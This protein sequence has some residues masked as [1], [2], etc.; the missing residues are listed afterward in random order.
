MTNKKTKQEYILEAAKLYGLGNV[1]INAL[2]AHLDGSEP[3][4]FI[5]RKTEY[6][7]RLYETYKSSEYNDKIDTDENGIIQLN[8]YA[9][10]FSKRKLAD[11]KIGT[12]WILS[13][14]LETYL[15]TK[16]PDYHSKIK[17]K[18]LKLADTN[19]FLLPQIA[20]QMGLDA[21][22]Y[23]RAEYIEHSDTLTTFHL[24]KNFLRDDETLIQGN[25]IVRESSKKKRV[26]KVNFETL[27]ETVDKYV[28]KYY[29]KHKL[30]T[31]NLNSVREEIR[32]NL[33]KQTIFNKMVFNQNESNQKW[34]L[35]K[36]PD[37]SLRTAPLFS[38]DYCSGVEM[39]QKSPHRVIDG[40][41]EDIES[42]MV[43]F[44]QEE[45]FREWIASSVL[46]LDLDKA[47]QDME[48]KTGISLS[49]EEKE[50]YQFFMNKMHDKIVSVHNL[51]YDK[52]LVEES[53]KI[54]LGDKIKRKLS[55]KAKKETEKDSGKD[56][57]ELEK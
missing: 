52:E 39:V 30:P 49:N 48:R 47:M 54:K 35:I 25:S 53:K 7:F 9:F 51:N 1:E 11:S 38:Y 34:G 43:K 46:P 19:N 13:S 50:Y 33:I 2:K 32:R 28:K 21:T 37:N 6:L 15:I 41:K 29:K 44:G 42:F 45:W 8:G 5:V 23:Y 4:D 57:L 22:I 14:N 26:T 24:T 55:R 12:G 40:K 10:E 31:E 16:T 36:S 20:K 27:L 3:N 17:D 56:E 18:Y